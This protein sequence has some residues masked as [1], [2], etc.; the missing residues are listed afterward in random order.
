MQ[1]RISIRTL[2]A[3]SRRKIGW[4]LRFARQP[5]TR[6]IKEKTRQ[7]MTQ[8]LLGRRNHGVR[9][10]MNTQSQRRRETEERRGDL[11]EGGEKFILLKAGCIKKNRAWL[12]RRSSKRKKVKVCCARGREVGTVVS[13]G[14]ES[15]DTKGP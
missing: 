3:P 8:G 5:E 11:T 1:M 6:L 9:N 7:Q 2:S 13:K 15:S 14:R 10:R 12:Q 4:A